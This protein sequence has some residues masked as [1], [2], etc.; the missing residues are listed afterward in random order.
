MKND[1]EQPSQWASS[2]SLG[3]LIATGQVVDIDNPNWPNDITTD[4]IVR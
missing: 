4:S 2:G 3:A 1:K